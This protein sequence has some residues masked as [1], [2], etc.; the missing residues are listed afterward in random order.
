ML[1]STSNPKV[2]SLAQLMKK[3]KVRS[4]EDL[5]V[6]EGMKMYLEAPKERIR[7]VYV[8]ESMYQAQKERFRG[9]PK[10]EILSDHVFASVSGTKTPR[11]FYVCSSSI[12]IRSG[13]F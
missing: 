11:E 3:A 5:F 8:S 6:A 1:T 4:A 2:K 12:T 13:I 7:Q 9:A 10:L